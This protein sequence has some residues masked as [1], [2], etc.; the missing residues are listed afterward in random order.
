MGTLVVVVTKE[1]VE[2]MEEGVGLPA[3]EEEDM[4]VVV[5][6]KVLGVVIKVVDVAIK[7][8]GMATKVAGVAIKVAGVAIK[9]VGVAIKVVGVV[10]KVVG[11]AT[12]DL[13]TEL[14]SEV[15]EA[16]TNCHDCIIMC[17]AQLWS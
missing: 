10:I 17:T 2:L 4:E 3:M 1:G 12:R 13:D 16:I 6:T 9:V 8:V 15:E 11:V 14:H 5:A 7:V